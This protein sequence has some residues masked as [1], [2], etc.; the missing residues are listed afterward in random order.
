MSIQTT[1]ATSGNALFLIL[2]AVALFAALSYAITQSGRGSGSITQEKI[3]IDAANII[4]YAGTVQ[5][6]INRMMVVN[7]CADTQIS[8][9]NPNEPTLY[10]NP[11]SPSDKSCHV[12][13]PNGGNVAWQAAPASTGLSLPYMFSGRNRLILS[14]HTWCA[15]AGAICVQTIA[16]FLPV[17]SE[18]MCLQINKGLSQPAALA[19]DRIN[20]ILFVGAYGVGND[21]PDDG[22]NRAG[23]K[24]KRSGCMQT[25]VGQY[26]Q[27]VGGTY[28]F[29]HVLT[30]IP[31]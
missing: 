8:F 10:A 21:M 24:G 25:D 22:G 12:F 18:S 30:E 14:S 26:P 17:A 27:T 28:F 19:I 29:Y 6:A 23:Y 16:M 2:I 11:T 4:Q 20:P 5:A 15:D 1:K 9:E 31:A 3:G 7:K 13:D